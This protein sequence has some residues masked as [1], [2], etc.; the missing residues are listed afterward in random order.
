MNDSRACVQIAQLRFRS[1]E[2]DRT[3]VTEVKRRVVTAYLSLV[4]ATLR[5]QL[6]SNISRGGRVGRAWLPKLPNRLLK[7]SF[8]GDV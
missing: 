4:I 3:E 5:Y 2:P 8:A 1:G 6:A 7:D